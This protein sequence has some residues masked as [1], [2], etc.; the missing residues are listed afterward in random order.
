[1]AEDAGHHTTLKYHFPSVK[2]FQSA[3]EDDL[4]DAAID[5]G[6][7]KAQLVEGGVTFEAYFRDVLQVARSLMKRKGSL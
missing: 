5:S 6:W 3:L 1:M 2:A 7:K 4:D